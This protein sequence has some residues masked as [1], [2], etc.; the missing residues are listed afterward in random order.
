M[1]ARIYYRD[2][3]SGGTWIELTTTVASE[4]WELRE[5]SEEGSVPTSTLPIPDG[6]MA[7]DIDGLRSIYVQE[8]SSALDDDIL[9]Y[10]YTWDQD[11]SRGESETFEPVG[12]SWG[13]NVVDRNNFW[14]RVVMRGSDCNRPAETDVDRMTWLLGTSEAAT[15]DDITSFFST[16]NTVAMDAVDYRGQMV[17]QVVSDCAEA[18]G[19]NWWVKVIN[20]G[21]GNLLLTVWYGKDTLDL[22][23]SA[24]LLTNDPTDMVEA[25]LED[26]SSLVWPVSEDTKV[27][28]DPSRLVCGIY[29]QYDGGATYRH[30]TT[31]HNAFGHFDK[32]VPMPNVKSKAKAQARADRMLGD[33]GTQYETCET[34]VRLSAANATQIRAGMRVQV[35]LTH[36]PGWDDWLWCRVLACTVSP[37]AAGS[38]YD[39]ALT[40]TPVGRP[41][42]GP[43]A[44]VTTGDLFAG[45]AAAGGNNPVVSGA[46]GFLGYG[47]KH[48]GPPPSGWGDIPLTGSI[49]YGQSSA[50]FY[51]FTMTADATAR[52]IARAWYSD[53]SGHVSHSVIVKV[54]GVTAGTASST[55]YS[56]FLTVDL[57]G[58][59]L[60]NGDVISVQ[61]N[62]QEF[63]SSNGAGSTYFVVVNGTF[64][65]YTGP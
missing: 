50:P 18:A 28:R 46:H 55:A 48:D 1:T 17:G 54:N 41:S 31:T 45:Y 63:W 15:F 8:T 19:K 5:Q 26:G 4:G 38:M 30:N 21:L 52:I 44:P 12:R 20:D 25:D 64:G 39:L 43:G 32:V 47:Y 62:V 11:I 40:L 61:S 56:N 23:D 27:N 13:L 22:Y 34:K 35:K 49:A 58:Y 65:S 53:N 57:P 7:L 29:A 59:T 37:V 60:H 51:S 36:I 16:A 6:A 3:E 2:A 24:Y 14:Q 42:P 9:Y 33:L 10:G